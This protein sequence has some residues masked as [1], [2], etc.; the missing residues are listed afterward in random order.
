MFL[1][2]HV[3]EALLARGHEVTLFHRGKHGAELFPQVERVLGDRATE[4]DRLSAYAT[5]DAV[6]DTS[7]FLPGVV[8]TSA[9][10]LCER[11]GRYVF[12]SSMSVYDISRVPLDE[13]SPTL[14]L[15]PDASREVM[16]PETYGALKALC[17]HEAFAAF[18][19]ERALIVRPGLIAG[20]GD[21]TDRFTYW[22]VRFMRGGD[23][24]VADDLDAPTPI[25]DVRD[26]AEFIVSGIER[27]LHG[28]VNT[29]G[30]QPPVRM[31]D[32]FEACAAASNI[33]SRIVPV[34][35]AALREHD[36]WEW[37]DLPAWIAPNSGHD[38][39]RNVDPSRSLAMGLRHRPLA[40]TVADTLHWAQHD[41][42][43]APLQAGLTAEREA[44]VLAARALSS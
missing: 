43:D 15:P 37:S 4:L 10:R 17:E 12:V 7:G 44:E 41:R 30:P 36:V 16:V 14:E 38:G 20:W 28:V 29:A 8:A 26:L 1:G 31:R 11:V 24:L 5:W 6:V 25:I 40:E 22:P 21:P 34:D 35:L 19:A 23:V 3:V 32:I 13:S 9:G 18:G 2:R 39:L 33:P 42:G 27:G